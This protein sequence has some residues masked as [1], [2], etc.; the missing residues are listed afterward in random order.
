ML[1]IPPPLAASLIDLA[2][3]GYP[4]EICGLLFAAGSGGDQAVRVLAMDNLADRLHALDPVEHP[5]TS[6]NY[7]T[8]NELKVSKAVAAAEAA[9]E[10]WLAIYHSHINC[11]AYFSA[12]DIAAAAPDGACVYPQIWQVVIDVRG[13][14]A[15]PGQSVP[16]A[17]AFRWDGRRFADHG[18]IAGLAR[19]G[20]RSEPPR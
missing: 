16:E 2:L 12:E 19:V 1:T 8:M 20:S 11:G 3:A 18:V 5:H 10:R 14:D 15:S 4:G 17:K 7:F 13:G 6:R 9:G